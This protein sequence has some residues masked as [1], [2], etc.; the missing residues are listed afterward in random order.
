V[1][2]VALCFEVSTN[3]FLL[4]RTVAISSA[5]VRKNAWRRK[6]YISLHSAMGEEFVFGHPRQNGLILSARSI[7]V[8]VENSSSKV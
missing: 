2:P 8:R 4:T 1:K 7:V 6:L 3:Y 5:V